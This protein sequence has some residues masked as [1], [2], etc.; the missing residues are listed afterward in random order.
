M[1][2]TDPTSTVADEGLHPAGDDPDWQE[3]AYLAWR[4]PVSGLGG[5]HRI[6]N[7]PNRKTANLWCGLYH[8][9]G[10]RFRCNG[11]ELE[12]V[13]LDPSAGVFGLCG[14]PQR[15]FH[16]GASLR[17]A[18]EGDGCQADLVITDSGGIQEEAPS[19]DKPVLVTRETTERTEGI[20]AGTLRLVGTDPALIFAEGAR[21]LEDADAYAKMASAPNPYGDGKAATRIAGALE[22]IVLGKNAPEPFGPGYSR[23][24]VALAPITDI[25]AEGQDFAGKFAA[26]NA[27]Q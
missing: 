12:Q 2:T 23:D 24:A 18:L 10:T 19:L 11:E 3:S 8:E 17:F 21:L 16:D 5:N 14:G 13:V 22:H 4:D 9:D 6:G 26:G 27:R 7:E 20:A 1:A 15:I 25:F